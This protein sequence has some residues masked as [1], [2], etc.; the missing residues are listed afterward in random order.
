M[1]ATV[2]TILDPILCGLVMITLFAIHLFVEYEFRSSSISHAGE[3]QIPQAI[4]IRS[5]LTDGL[6]TSYR[7]TWSFTIYFIILHAICYTFVT[8]MVFPSRRVIIASSL[9][10]DTSQIL[11]NA[12][13]KSEDVLDRTMDSSNRIERKS[14]ISIFGK[15]DTGS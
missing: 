11:D 8:R 4:S 14:E 7:R 10:N 13:E 9:S 1:N 5:Y 2:L 12:T 15:P 6:N 3:Q